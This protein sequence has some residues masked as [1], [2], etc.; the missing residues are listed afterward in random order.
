[1]GWAAAGGG[2]TR[3][4]RAIIATCAA[5]VVV[6][7]AAATRI[8]AVTVFAW[9]ASVLGWSAATNAAATVSAV[10]WPVCRGAAIVS[11]RGVVGKVGYRVVVVVGAGGDGA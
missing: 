5:G 10:A 1:M 7:A 3:G 6:S 9:S 2:G 4:V 8:I 11:G